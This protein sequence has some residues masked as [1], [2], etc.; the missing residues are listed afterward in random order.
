MVSINRIEVYDQVSY[1][2]WIEFDRSLGLHNVD[3]SLDMKLRSNGCELG[4]GWKD[5]KALLSWLKYLV[6]F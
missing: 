5:D 2:K 3:L 4:L 1:G 6:H